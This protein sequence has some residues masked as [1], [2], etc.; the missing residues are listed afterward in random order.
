MKQARRKKSATTNFSEN[1]LEYFCVNY[2]NLYALPGVLFC[3]V[4]NEG[5]RSVG[6]KIHLKKMGLLAGWP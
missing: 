2:L 4:P 5:N 1:E 3:H 6:Q